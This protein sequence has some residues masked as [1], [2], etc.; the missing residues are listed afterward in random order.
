[1]KTTAILLV[2][3][4]LIASTSAFRVRT[5]TNMNNRL[6]NKLKIWGCRGSKS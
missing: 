2:A 6:Q 5:N 3:L 4:L 1:M